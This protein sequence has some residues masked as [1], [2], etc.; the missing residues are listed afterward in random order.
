MGLPSRP[1]ASGERDNPKKNDQPAQGFSVEGFQIE[2]K[3][4]EYRAGWKRSLA[5]RERIFATLH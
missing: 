5:K 2:T 1:A 4:L 3:W